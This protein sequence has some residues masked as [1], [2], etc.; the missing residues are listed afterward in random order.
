MEN[1]NVLEL[2]IPIPPSINNDYKA[3]RIMASKS[4]KK[5]G[6]FTAREVMKYF[7]PQMFMM[8]KALDFKKQMKNKVCEKIKN[9]NFPKDNLKFTRVGFT[10]FFPRTNMDTNNYYKCPLDVITEIGHIWEDDNKTMITD[11]RIFYDSEN[12]R[13][14]IKIYQEDFCGI[15]ENEKD[16]EEFKKEFCYNCKKGN[17]IGQKGG[18]SVYKKAI[19]SRIQKDMEFDYKTKIKKC[20][21]FKQK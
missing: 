17:K 3:P 6:S 11:N 15:F 16:L 4:A 9:S 10:F 1:K 13:V 12:P 18:C 8:K 21:K 19:E 14:E 5:K 7:H 2:V 20:L